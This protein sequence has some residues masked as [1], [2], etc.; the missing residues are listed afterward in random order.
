MKN[1]AVFAGLVS[2]ILSGCALYPDVAEQNV[3]LSHEDFSTNY[4][5]AVTTYQNEADIDAALMLTTIWTMMRQGAVNDALSEITRLE[6]ID[7]SMRE[8]ASRLLP[9]SADVL[10][11]QSYGADRPIPDLEIVADDAMRIATDGGY[12]A[13]LFVAVEPKLTAG[14]S[15]SED[16]NVQLVAFTQL[17]KVIPSGDIGSST[18]LLSSTDSVYCT[19]PAERIKEN[20]LKTMVDSCVD[21]LAARLVASF[22]NRMQNR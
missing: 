22:E 11:R 4:R 8:V 1:L 18:V 15:G 12:Q 20:Q 9:A 21:K 19:K 14:I 6:K 5:V 7:V 2:A 17:H 3:R 16:F 10:E 13:L